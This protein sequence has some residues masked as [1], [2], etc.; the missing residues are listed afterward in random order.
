MHSSHR[1]GLIEV[2]SVALAEAW[3]ATG[4][5]IAVV[6]GSGTALVSLL[7]HTPVYVASLRGGV[8]WAAVLAVTSLGAWLA[9]RT[10]RAPVGL[11]DGDGEVGANADV[12]PQRSRAKS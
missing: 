3:R 11:G 8:V 7:Q 10:W 5:Q 9:V 2:S 4:R 6:A 12:A 1:D